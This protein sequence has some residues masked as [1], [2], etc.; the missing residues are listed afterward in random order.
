MNT[1][2]AQAIV[3]QCWGDGY[4][5]RWWFTLK[6]EEGSTVHTGEKRV[7]KFDAMADRDQ[8][9]RKASDTPSEHRDKVQRVA[10]RAIYL[11]RDPQG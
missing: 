9:I 1:N 4:A 2:A 5:L 3:E 11:T 10:N 6:D 8:M 7:T